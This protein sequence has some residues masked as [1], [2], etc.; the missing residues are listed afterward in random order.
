MDVA[1]FVRSLRET[2]I[3]RDY[4]RL[5]EFYAE[6]AVAVSP[7]FG[8]VRGRAAI[9][10]TFK[11][12]F[13]M[14][15]DFTFDVTE[16]FA[17]GNRLAFFGVV[18]ATDEHGWF[19][20]PP[21]GTSFRYRLTIVCTVINGRIIQ[22]ERQYDLTG[23]VGRLEK[24]RLDAELQI[25]SD[26]QS[27]LLPR[28]L[29]SGRRWEVAADSIPS[30]GIGGDFFELR[31][32]PAG[33]LAIALGDV[34]GKGIPAA[35]VAAMLHGMFAADAQAE[36]RPAATLRKMNAQLVGD[37]REGPGVVREKGTRFASLI[38]GVLSPD[39]RFLYSNAGHVRP[40]LFAGREVI[41]LGE[42]GPILGAFPG[43]TYREAE[44]RL[45]AGD[46]LL[47]FSDGATEARNAEDEE[48]GEDRLLNCAAGPG[49]DSPGEILGRV[50]RTIRE[51]TGTSPQSDDI[52]LSV[53]RFK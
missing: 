53:T 29:K 16:S 13:E 33:G 23:V 7:V 42:G 40:A 5:A 6:D 11:K 31:D 44:I 30:R 8:E 28:I 35:L 17:D 1:A 12:T 38:Y 4:E 21:T 19:G 32:L 10:E 41:R 52:T 48:F 46:T 25:A 37:S 3:A 39:G 45:S 15:P 24:A 43:A 26:V 51:F 18:G 36:I 49:E 27:A 14:L 9:I 2:V 22:E 50:F 47:T 34:E 20:L